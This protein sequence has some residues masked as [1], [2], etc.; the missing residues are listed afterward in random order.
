MATIARGR[1]ASHPMP[2]PAVQLDLIAIILSD[3]EAASAGHFGAAAFPET[4]YPGRVPRLDR[5][6]PARTGEAQWRVA[7][8]TLRVLGPSNSQKKM[9]C[10]VPRA[11][12][13]P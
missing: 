5:L 3:A 12:F 6:T 9:P 13:P 10:H 8:S 7:T 1:R 11:G 4:A 2:P